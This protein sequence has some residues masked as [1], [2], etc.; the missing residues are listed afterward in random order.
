MKCEKCGQNEA[1][2]H[3]VTTENGITNETYLC[4]DC[5]GDMGFAAWPYSIKDMFS[6]LLPPQ[7]TYRKACSHCGTSLADVKRSGYAGCPHCYTDLREEMLPMIK[8]IH[9][10]VTHT[11]SVPKHREETSKKDTAAEQLRAKLKQAIEQERY[12]EAAQMRDQIRNM[13]ANMKARGGTEHA[14]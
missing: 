4:S 13:E 1:S 3:F 14:E 7:Q 10:S 11:G 5:A 9:G 2:M 8:A 12:E 6:S